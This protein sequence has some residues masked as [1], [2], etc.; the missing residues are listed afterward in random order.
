MGKNIKLT[1]TRG[2]IA[3]MLTISL[4]YLFVSDTTKHITEFITLYMVVINY[5][6]SVD[7]STEDSNK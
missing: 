1:S 3:V 5:L 2:I 7:K 6:F 4:V